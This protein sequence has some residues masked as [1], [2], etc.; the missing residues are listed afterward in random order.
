MEI[1]GNLQLLEQ[2][3]VIYREKAVK[4]R[5]GDTLSEVLHGE[6][7]CG[8]RGKCGKCRMIVTGEVSP[9]TDSERKFVSDE[10]LRRGVRLSCMTRVM[11]DCRALPLAEHEDAK[12]LTA[13]KGA[14]YTVNPTFHRYG[15]A[16]DVGTTTVV[17]RLY[18][19]SGVCLSSDAVLNP[20][21]E[22][23][24]DVISRIEAS[25]RGERE[26]LAEAI[27]AAISC[28]LITLAE[29]AGISSHE[30]DR[31]VITGNTV[32]LSLLSGEDVTLFS[33][34]PFLPR[35]LFG[36][37][38]YADALALDALLPKTPIYLPPC[39]S[40]FVGADVLCAALA[41]GMTEK[42]GKMLLLDIG[43]NGEMALLSHSRLTVCST[44][45]GPAFEGVGIS[46]GMRGGEGAIDRVEIVNGAPVAH[47][48]GG[49]AARGI[50]GSG[51]VDAVACLLDTEE[52]EETGYLLTD[53][54][55]LTPTVSLVG[56]DIREVQLAKSAICA[57]IETLLER[58]RVQ[59]KELT[60]VYIAGGFGTYLHMR[61]AERIG[62]LPKEIA[63]AATAVGNA[64][65][66]GA[67]MLLLNAFAEKRAVET[68]RRAETL[69]L[70]TDASFAERY[71]MGMMFSAE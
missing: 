19:T 14:V 13:A 66:E 38:I 3:T 50:C 53:P 27:R 22:W 11:G 46:M 62:L 6:K 8:G 10:E 30:I 57:G 64:A 15:A 21:S 45:A 31:A 35:R 60:A 24:A 25:M 48:I 29:R 69:S 28:M 18:D 37:T 23:G 58:C 42:E 33:H 2:A 49:G 7:P 63:R 67:A 51:L 32:M 17:G 61:N 40:A 26:A 68:A 12:I 52:L 56:R 34:A 59:A 71:M 54:V 1:K 41:V 44:A 65:L 47:V 55:Y 36:E 43:T 4:A 39:I 70:A 16:I 9:V 5:V 20:Q